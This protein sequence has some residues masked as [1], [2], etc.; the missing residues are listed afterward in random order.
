MKN[1]VLLGAPGSGKGTQAKRLEKLGYV[2]VSTGDLLRAEI[3]KESELGKRVKSVM[4]GGQLVSDE[5]VAEL[6]KANLDLDSKS[7]IFD[8]FPRNAAQAG[9]L[10]SILSGYPVLAVYF[11]I[12]LEVVTKRLVNRR[13]TPDGKYIYNLET[14]PPKVSGVCDVSGQEL[15][16]RDDDKEETVRKRM[17]V[18][19]EVVNGVVPHYRSKDCLV[20]INADNHVDEVYDKLAMAIGVK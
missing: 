8:G 7:Y 15:I 17:D 5:L 4:D 6:L 14:N 1:L 3:A 13:V 18:F 16:Q 12:D 10:D 19:Q 2:H 9:I 11:K 20:E